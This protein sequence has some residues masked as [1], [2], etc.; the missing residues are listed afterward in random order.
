[1]LK[2]VSEKRFVDEQEKPKP[3]DKKPL[4]VPKP[5]WNSFINEWQ[6][7][8][9]GPELANR[10]H[11]PDVHFIGADDTQ[12]PGCDKNMPNAKHIYDNM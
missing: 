6:T 10:K 5:E 4:Y 3:K 2:K 12:C 9:S 8:N 1:M 11:H 7:K